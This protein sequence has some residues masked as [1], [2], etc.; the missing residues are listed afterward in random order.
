M[1]NV[2][3]KTEEG[4]YLK[5]GTRVP[6][7]TMEKIE[8][9]YPWIVKKIESMEEINPHELRIHTKDGRC[10]IY[11][12]TEER[13]YEI[14]LFDDVRSLDEKEWRKGFASKLRRQMLRRG[15]SNYKLVEALDISPTT[16][17]NYLYARSTPPS[18]ILHKIAAVLGCSIEDLYPKEYVQLD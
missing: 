5:R 15:M 4:R 13:M 2:L 7:N 6:E 1:K 18:Y 8:W 11:S 14:K 3:K 16:L 17:S 12:Y 9:T 10:Y